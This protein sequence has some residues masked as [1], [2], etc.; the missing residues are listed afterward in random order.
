LACRHDIVDVDVEVA[1]GRAGV[2][3]LNPQERIRNQ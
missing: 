3:A 2:E 1:T